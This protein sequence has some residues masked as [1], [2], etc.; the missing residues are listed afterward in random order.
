[1]ENPMGA[2]RHLWAAIRLVHE[3]EANLSAT[4]RS[5][6]T[7]I[8]SVIVHLDFMAQKLVPYAC[9]SFLRGSNPAFMELPFWSR[10]SLEFS[11]ITE[12]DSIAVER[13]RLIQ[14]ISGHNKLSRVV[15]GSWYPTRDRPSRHELLGFY[16]ELLLWKANSPTT[17]ASCPELQNSDV[18]SLEVLKT[19][20]VPPQ[21]LQFSYNDAAVNVII[22][23][24][25]L[26]CALATIST[27]DD[28]PATRELEAF[29]L[30]YQT[31]CICEGLINRTDQWSAKVYKPCDAVCM[32]ISV[33]L[34]HGA[35]RC[36][37][38]AWQQYIVA[39]LRSIGHEGLSNGHSLANTLEVMCQLET[40]SHHRIP[41]ADSDYLL[42]SPLGSIRNRL[43]PLLMP[44]GEDDQLLAY[45]L[46]FGT[47]EAEG[48]E[49]TLRAI[50]KAT[51]KQEHSGIME[52]LRVSMYNSATVRDL[53]LPDG[54]EALELFSPWRNAV[55]KGWHGYLTATG[56]HAE[57]T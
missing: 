28:D 45:Y 31:L 9:S 51:W 3:S 13:Y 23:N 5:N 20:P 6:L 46:R 2:F 43:I 17:F 48:D 55:E 22:F 41:F 35:R 21:P 25:Y 8:Y 29:S 16:A 15:W 53:S 7:P 42:N 26:G 1:M 44:R 12:P 14:L 57:S 30:V 32:G 37:S 52:S 33:Y 47:E 40:E 54:Q 10:P 27:T 34:Y 38:L 36:Y 24:A 56:L 39:A 49:R 11:G 18:A 50:A 4:E 19:L